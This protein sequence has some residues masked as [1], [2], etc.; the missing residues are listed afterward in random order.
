VQVEHVHPGVVEHVLECGWADGDRH[1]IAFPEPTRGLEP[2]TTSLRGCRYA[3][4]L[5]WLSHISRPALCS[6]E[7]RFPEFGTYFG[8]RFGG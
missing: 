4:I 7:L 5:A 2:R 6:D 8:T 3:A 1:N